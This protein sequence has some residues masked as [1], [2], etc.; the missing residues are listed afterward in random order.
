[1]LTGSEFAVQKKIVQAQQQN[2]DEECGA[3]QDDCLSCEAL[4]ASLAVGKQLRVSEEVL[5]DDLPSALYVYK[6]TM[7]ARVIAVEGYIDVIA[8]VTAGAETSSR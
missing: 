5:G 3:K 6:G 4:R 8:M 1:M 2:R 7:S